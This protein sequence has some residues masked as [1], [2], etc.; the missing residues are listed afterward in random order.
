MATTG[1][2][3]F[4]AQNIQDGF[5]KKLSKGT[6]EVLVTDNND[7]PID[8]TSGGAG[9]PLMAQSTAPI[10][11]TNGAVPSDAVIPD[12][13][14]SNPANISLRITIKDEEGVTRWCGK[15]IQTPNSSGFN[16]DTWKP[17][18]AP[19]A[20]VQAGPTGPTGPAGV[21]GAAGAFQSFASVSAGLAGVSSGSSFLVASATVDGFLDLYINNSGTAQL[22][23]T[24]PKINAASGGTALLEMRDPSGNSIVLIDEFGNPP[25]LASVQTS[26]AALINGQIGLISPSGPTPLSVVDLLGNVWDAGPAV[27]LAPLKASVAALTAVST[28]SGTYNG[29]QRGPIAGTSTWPASVHSTSVNVVNG[30]IPVIAANDSYDLQ[31]AFYATSQSE[32]STGPDGTVR[33]SF[34]YPAGVF[35]PCYFGGKRTGTI[36]GGTLPVSD[37][38]AINVPAGALVLLH[39]QFRRAAGSSAKAIPAGWT[40]GYANGAGVLGSGVTNARNGGNFF[41]AIEFMVERTITDATY[42]GTTMTSAS[43]AFTYYE[44]N[45]VA[46]FSDGSTRTYTFVSATQATLSSAPNSGVTSTVVLSAAD[47]T[48]GAA[49]YA[50]ASGGVNGQKG[51]YVAGFAPWSVFGR[52]KTNMAIL[53]LGDSITWGLGLSGAQLP[54]GGWFE[55]GLNFGKGVAAPLKTK[56]A[57][58]TPSMNASMPGETTA[59]LNLKSATRLGHCW[60]FRYV[61]GMM[62]TNDVGTSFSSTAAATL[63]AELLKLW[64][65]IAAY[66]SRPVYSTIIPR[67]TTSSDYSTLAAQ[68]TVGSNPSRV[69]VNAWLMDGAP[70]SSTTGLAVAVGSSSSTTNRCNVYSST[71]ALVSEASGPGTH[72]CFAVFDMASVVDAGVV[73]GGSPNGLWRVDLGAP[74]V[75]GVHPNQV[76]HYAM[77]GAFAAILKYLT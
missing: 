16:L 14:L 7:R 6:L 49:D 58:I 19:L 45:Q 74:T 39:Y 28:L 55:Q 63:E 52:S 36:V 48:L 43:A 12:T 62:G 30:F 23:G 8:T 38:V 60:R 24:I 70:A 44:T 68:T 46:T 21:A 27:D 25:A 53:G 17:D 18:Q 5:G 72:P 51:V 77:A 33:A 1:W 3:P 15:R 22:V 71:G 34:E 76:I 59:S 37:P 69:A 75:D 64:V 73:A 13:T 42:S 65:S 29:N 50:Y 67:A 32:S 56:I 40:F 10:V 35:R 47:K 11:V 54:A 66:G 31:A 57:V 2:V 26:V 61:A 4:T 20:L 9:G 41:E